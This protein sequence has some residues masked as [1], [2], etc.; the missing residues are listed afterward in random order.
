M[1][2]YKRNATKSCVPNLGM[3][4]MNLCFLSMAY[5]FDTPSSSTV[6]PINEANIAICDVCYRSLLNTSDGVVSKHLMF[7]TPKPPPRFRGVVYESVFHGVID[8]VMFRDTILF[9]CL[10]DKIKLRSRNATPANMLFQQ[11]QKTF[12]KKDVKIEF[13]PL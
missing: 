13:L 5:R 6:F 11:K 7:S 4:V 12:L 8:G 9:Y 1:P 10:P 3:Q 2:M